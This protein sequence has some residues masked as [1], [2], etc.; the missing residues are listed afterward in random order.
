VLASPKTSI[1][2]V[3]VLNGVYTKTLLVGDETAKLLPLLMELSKFLKLGDITCLGDVTFLGDST[4]L[5]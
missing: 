3:E 1:A 4:R 5:V 2:F